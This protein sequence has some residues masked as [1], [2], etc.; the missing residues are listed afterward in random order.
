MDCSYDLG[1]KDIRR[2]WSAIALWDLVVVTS[3]NAG[4]EITHDTILRFFAPQGRYVYRL[5][6]NLVLWSKLKIPYVMSNFTQIGPHM[7]ISDP[8]N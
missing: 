6:P 8:K 2:R 7:G 5:S 4:I 1:D 3:R